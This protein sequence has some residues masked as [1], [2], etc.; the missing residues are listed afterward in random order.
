MR[1][2]SVRLIVSLILGS[3]LVSLLFSYSEV[4]GEKRS[5]RS[6]LEHRAEVLGESLASNVERSWSSGS[7]AELQRLVQRFGNR[8][9]LLGVAVYDRRGTRVAITPGLEKL[10]TSTPAAVSRAISETQQ[11]NSFDHLAGQRVHILALPLERQDELVG[12]LAVVHE[13]D[14][15]RQQTLRAWREAFLRVLSEVFLIVLITL[16][17]VRWSITGPIARAAQWMRALRTGRVSSRQEMPDLDFFRP[18]AREVATLAESLN[19]ARYA[20][21]NEARLREAAESM[22]TADRL[23]VQVRTR[24]DGSRLFVVS[25]REPY[26]HQRNGKDD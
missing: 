8:E 19:Q 22:W 10:L 12:G 21:E 7:E 17:I 2:L 14:Y 23:S 15:I 25:N 1:L 9:H 26:M 20:A 24:L 5:L 11:Q 4:V 13:A 3:T 18:L 16:L 6:D